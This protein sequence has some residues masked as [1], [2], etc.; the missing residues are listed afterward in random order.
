MSILR[1]ACSLL[2]LCLFALVPLACGPAPDGGQADWYGIDQY[3][4]YTLNDCWKAAVRFEWFRDEEGTRVG[5]N[6]PSN[7]NTPPFA[8]SFYSLSF[9]VNW[10]PTENLI[11]RPEVRVDWYDGN[12][13][14]QPFDDGLDD[15]QVLVGFDAILRF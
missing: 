8:G 7:P 15:S 13:A 6:R 12:P 1:T 9:G 3:L 11:V 14:T 10:T 5:L 2:A 4:Y